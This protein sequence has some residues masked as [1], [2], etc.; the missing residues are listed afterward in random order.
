[1]LGQSLAASRNTI[2]LKFFKEA[3]FLYGDKQ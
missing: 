3:N 2:G 1:M